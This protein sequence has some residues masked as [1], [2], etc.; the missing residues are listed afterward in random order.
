GGDGSSAGAA[1]AGTSAGSGLTAD[2]ASPG[3][4]ATA[5][6][7]GREGASAAATTRRPARRALFFTMEPDADA[8]VPA[9]RWAPGAGP[10]A[11]RAS[12]SSRP[13]N[14]TVTI[15]SV[16]ETRVVEPP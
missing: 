6:G 7:D 11:P 3:R 8:D 14:L 15:P 1:A 13:P 4:A 5:T 9:G 10:T 2:A 16:T 12:R